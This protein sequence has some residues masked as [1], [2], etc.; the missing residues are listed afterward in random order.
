VK[1]TITC[2][3]YCRA[4]QAERKCRMTLGGRWACMRCEELTDKLFKTIAALW[5]SL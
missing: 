5:R 1:S 3:M 2:V 4:C